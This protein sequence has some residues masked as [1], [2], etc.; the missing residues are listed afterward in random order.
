MPRQHERKGL[1]GDI[2][3]LELFCLHLH[4]GKPLACAAQHLNTS[5]AQLS[6][7]THSLD[8]IQIM[9]YNTGKVDTSWIP[10]FETVA[11]LE[12]WE[13]SCLC[14]LLLQRQQ[15]QHDIKLS[16]SCYK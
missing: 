15:S 11:P 10:Q 16:I 2:K 12:L 8:S 5:F 9:I 1:D 3:I 4:L 6:A 14:M 13:K 7:F